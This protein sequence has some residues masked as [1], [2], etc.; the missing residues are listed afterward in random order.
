[1]AFGDDEARLAGVNLSGNT[2]RR[3]IAGC[4]GLWTL[5]LI[6]T[7]CHGGSPTTTTT[8]AATAAAPTAPAPTAPVPTG[9][10]ATSTPPAA[11]PLGP[12]RVPIPDG[13]TLAP[14]VSSNYPQTID[15]IQCQTTE[16]LVY[17]IHAHLT[18]FVGGQPRQVPYGIGIAPP[19]QTTNYPVGV[20][21]SGGTCFY[22]LHTHVADGVIHIESP[23]PKLYTLGQFFDVY[24]Q[25]L[26]PNQVGP[27]MGAVTV[28]VNGQPYTGNPRDVSLAA[29]AEV[30]L[31]VGTVV[32][33]ER[34]DWGPTG[35]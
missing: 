26:G 1:L 31:D 27:A 25:P 8:T 35:L 28:F 17:H 6:A 20:F 33:P 13:P 7:A 16:Q 4:F 34:I 23:S 22:W 15:G 29:H 19:I 18:V 11:G 32:A 24:G 9:P 5:A 10:V 2:P 14:V 21:V 3:R 30:Q 12:E